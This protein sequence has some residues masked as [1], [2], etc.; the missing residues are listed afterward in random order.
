[1]ASASFHSGGPGSRKLKNYDTIIN[2]FICQSC[3]I[4]FVKF[5]PIVFGHYVLL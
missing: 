2:L 5:V 4:W 3:L 1:M